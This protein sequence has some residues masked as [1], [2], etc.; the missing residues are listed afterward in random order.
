M[1]VAVADP[2]RTAPRTLAVVPLVTTRALA[3]PLTYAA[4]TEGT[5]TVGSVVTVPLHGRLVR[6]VVVPADTA[7]PHD[8][9]LLPVEEVTE[10]PPVPEALVRVALWI[11]ARYGS[12]PARAL[13]LVLGPDAPPATEVLAELVP[14]AEP[15]TAAQ[16]R[17]AEALARGPLPAGTL[18]ARAEVTRPTIRRLAATGLLSL[19][20]R[21]ARDPAPAASAP[22]LPT[23]GQAEATV[24]IDELLR[25]GEGELL[26]HGVTGS[27]KTEVYLAAVARCLDLG[28]GALVLVPEIALAPQTAG[29]L[30]A[31]FGDRVVVLH[32]GLS[33]GAR[34]AAHA[35]LR[36]GEADVVVGARS[37]VFA[38]VP[39]LGLVVVDEEHDPSYKQGDD[40]RYD[41]RAVAARRARTEGAVLVL[42]SA[43]P[44]PESW[45]G[46]PRT[47][48]SERVGGA[49]PPVGVVDLCRDGLYPLS[50]PL[51][52]R[53]GEIAEDGGRGILLVSRR[54][55]AAALVCRSCGGRFTCGRCDISL[56]LHPDG[57]MRCHHCGHVEAAPQRCPSCGA[58]DLARLGAGTTR[59][60]EAVRELCGRSVEVLALDTDH[61]G[62]RGVLEETL[63]RF[64]TA[65]SAVLVGTQMVAKGHDF[66]DLRLAAAIDADSGLAWPDFR[67]E[68]RTFALLTQLAGRSARLGD[69]GRVLVQS[70][71]PHGRVV[72]LAARHAVDEFLAGELERRELLGYP[73]F[74]Q[75]VRVEVAA[76]AAD[77]PGRALEALRDAAAPALSGDELL[78][79]AP[80]FRVRGR[81]RAQ[82]LVKTA[83][84]GR[85]ASVLADLV[86]RQGRALR[87]AQAQAVVDVDPL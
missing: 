68:E 64:A 29:R 32:S 16:R 8:G 10:R 48:L 31:R 42:G 1:A 28:R 80:L 19:E 46:L 11:A 56:S 6:G 35:R 69:A 60:A 59:V 34:A 62:R 2:S 58:V 12:T 71:E 84:A 18:A 61:V 66:R 47:V 27:G 54:G 4:P 57:R 67:A 75:L 49:L 33:T 3:R 21:L 15:R 86:A 7:A 39:R 83:R 38:P 81:H 85:A 20:R 87:R 23:P 41:A 13:A 25:A 45:H 30:A 73:P 24:R 50:R 76:P 51:R 55:E 82:I 43:T 44:R 65:R 52:D 77:V 72:E 70:W 78:G 40:P 5:V 79:P 14:G 17:I 26:V 9:P 36:G 74:R 37:A 53:L 63:E 22:P